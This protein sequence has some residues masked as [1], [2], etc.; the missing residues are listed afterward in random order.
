MAGKEPNNQNEN[1]Q[2]DELEFE[3][4]EETD[5][6]IGE[7]NIDK[8]DVLANGEKE[9][10]KQ[11]IQDVEDLDALLDDSEDDLM[12]D[13]EMHRE[14]LREHRRHKED[15]RRNQKMR[16]KRKTK[17]IGLGVA[18]VLVLGAGA[19]FMAKRYLPSNEKMSGYVYFH[20]EQQEDAVLLFVNGQKIDAQGKMIDGRVYL[21]RAD[22]EQYI[23]ERFYWDVE[24]NGILY[25]DAAKN[26]TFIFPIDQAKYISSNGVE[27]QTEYPVVKSDAEQVYVAFDYVAQKTACNYVF[28]ENP[29]R[30]SVEIG[31]DEQTYVTAKKK[32]AVRYR[33]GIKSD[34]LE[35]V[36]KGSKL[37]PGKEVDE[38]W[39]EVT[40]QSGFTGY[41]KK[42]DISDPVT[43]VSE[44]D[45]QEVYQTNLRADKVNL[46]WFQVTNA[47]ANTSIDSYL[48]GVQGINT[49][50]PTWYSIVDE[51]GT[52]SRIASANFVNQMHSRGYEVWPLVND[53]DKNVDY[54]VL[55]ASKTARTNLANQLIADAQTFHYDGI[56]LDFENI[57]ADYAAGYLQFVRELSVLCEKNNIKLSIDN[58]KPASFNKFYNLKEQAVFADYIIIMG[59]DEHY[60]GSKT[61]GSV[62]SLPFVREGIEGALKSVPS[63]QLINALPFYTRAWTTSSSGLSSKAYGIQSSIDLMNQNGAQWLWNE[64]TAQYYCAF[65]QSDATVEIWFEEERSI[66]EKMKLY[67]EYN[68]A[69]VASWKLGLERAGV[70]PV[71]SDGLQY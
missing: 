63:N 2:S 61:A 67:A 69:G 10:A 46:S 17:W 62:A 26:E 19:A 13:E 57:K 44:Y 55:F 21:T 8:E 28:V 36:A 5:N 40:T 66:E 42:S 16:K 22:M 45:Y 20:M 38:D 24:T 3:I 53:F 12:S 70:W 65:N 52:T 1:I 15:R 33:A 64:A 60:A 51:A 41:I 7:E 9:P 27:Y 4:L 47:T 54:A 29:N 71:I 30:L 35:E 31:D 48:E 11:D 34:V 37:Y 25:T 59:Y 18:A 58:Y 56:N 6:S 50:S 39:K 43:A 68:L 32:A 49:I 23:N 14:A